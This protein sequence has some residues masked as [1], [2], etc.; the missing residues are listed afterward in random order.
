MTVHRVLVSDGQLI[1]FSL[2]KTVSFNFEKQLTKLILVRLVSATFFFVSP[3]F[4]LLL[5]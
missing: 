5:L 4:T 3:F 2:T 1:F